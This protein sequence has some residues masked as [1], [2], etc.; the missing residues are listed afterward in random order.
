MSGVKPYLNGIIF[1]V[2]VFGI[3]GW[4]LVRSLKRSEDPA[5][6]VFKWVLTALVLSVLVLKVVPI[7]ADGGYVGAF[8]GIPA[9][10]V[11]GLV[12]AII[13]HQNLAG[14]IAKPF[15][16]LYDGG[17]RELDP[18]PSYSLALSKCKRGNYTEAIAEIH[19][20]LAQFPHDVQGQL[21]IAQIQAQYLDDMPGA[22]LTIQRLCNQPGHPP[23]VIAGALNS[24][25]DWHLQF[26]SD[27]EPARQALE[28]II[29]LL[30]D[31]QLSTLASQRIAHLP[32]VEFLCERHDRRKIEVVEGTQNMGLIDP[33]FHP[34]PVEADPEKLAAELI[35]HLQIHPLDTDARERLAV[36]YA[37]HYQRLDLAAGQLEQLITDPKQR[38]VRVVHWLNLLADLQLRLGADYNTIRGTFE[39]IVE[40]FPNSAT[41][42]LARSRIEHLKLA[43]KAKVN[44]SSVKLGAMEAGDRADVG[45]EKA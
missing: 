15:A 11:C 28:K 27:P 14:L 26:G 22:D 33:R 2:M 19:K 13:W 37:D 20:Q 23:G 32:T 35:E 31:S 41:E 7:V 8:G 38:P 44:T 42:G 25:A 17:A 43:M 12:L 30:P 34:K 5:R 3:C 9:A 45:G 4:L 6:L 1:L 16:D 40:R 24:Q 29:E 36:I 10:A 21:L 39:R 18:E